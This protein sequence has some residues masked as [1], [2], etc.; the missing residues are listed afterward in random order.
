MYVRACMCACMH[1]C[2]RVCVRVV[3]GEKSVLI[4]CVT[5]NSTI[6]KYSLYRGLADLLYYVPIS[7]RVHCWRFSL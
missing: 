5:L 1:L 2:V 6:D 7:R 4:V 3:E